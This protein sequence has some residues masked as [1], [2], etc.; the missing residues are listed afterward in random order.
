MV[1]ILDKT[2]ITTSPQLSGTPLVAL[3]IGS[4][5]PTQGQTYALA[6]SCTNVGLN[7][8]GAGN[9]LNSGSPG[10]LI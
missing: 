10:P 1:A 2:G 3:E 6:D 5:L 4:Y 9:N 7:D 8:P